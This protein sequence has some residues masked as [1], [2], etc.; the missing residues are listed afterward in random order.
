MNETTKIKLSGHINKAH[1]GYIA[2]VRV[3]KGVNETP[4]MNL[5]Y[6]GNSLADVFIPIIENFLNETKQIWIE[7]RQE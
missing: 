4:F 2:Y 6:A 7:I 1:K 5:T 3:S